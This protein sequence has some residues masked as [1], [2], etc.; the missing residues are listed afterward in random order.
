MRSTKERVVEKEVRPPVRF[1]DVVAR[2]LNV[3]E[4]R[5]RIAA[6]DRRSAFKAKRRERA[7]RPS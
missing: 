6:S 5:R 3:G 2:F 1:I 7:S 4:Q